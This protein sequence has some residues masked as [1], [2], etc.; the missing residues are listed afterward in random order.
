MC[1]MS[2]KKRLDYLLMMII[3]SVLVPIYF[4]NID[5]GLLI[6]TD[7]DISKS[8][9]LVIQI[10]PQLHL[11]ILKLFPTSHDTNKIGTYFSMPKE[12]RFILI[13][14]EYPHVHQYCK[15]RNILS[16]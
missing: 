16:Y 12:M 11:L 5:I 13:C 7:N 6:F 4:L 10:A 1:H 9:Q 14:V 8:F 2:V 3:G 15:L